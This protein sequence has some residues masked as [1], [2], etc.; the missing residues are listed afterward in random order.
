MTNGNAS[1]AVA[2][3]ASPAATGNAGRNAGRGLVW[4]AGAKLYFI[5]SGYAVQLLL[6]RLLGS[7]ETFGLFS[8][9]LSQV[10]ILN[11]VL[12]AATV[13]AVSRQ[14]SRD[15]PRAEQSL[16]Q[17]LWLQLLLGG[18]LASLLALGAPW[19][20]GTILLD[21][22][23]GVLLRIAAITVFCY[24][25]YAA[26]I[27]ALNGKQLFHVQAR[28][29]ATYTTSRMVGMLGAAALGFGVAGAVFGLASAALLVLIV[30]TFVVGVGSAGRAHDW[31]SWLSF[32]APLWLY[33]LCINLALQVDLS[34]LK[35]TV[36]ALALDA[37][38]NQ[39]A[40]ADA[41]SR[42]AGFYRAAQTFAFVPYQL[43]L[44][45]TFVV[46]PMV[47]QAQSAG[48]HESSRRYVQNALRFSLLVL[49][50]IAAPVSGAAGGVMRLAYPAA[51][52]S[53]SGALALL[54]PGMVCF[55]LFVIGATILSGSGRP[56]LSAV[57][58]I[59]TVAVVMLCNWLF[60]RSAGLGPQTLEAA[61]A[62]TALGMACALVAMAVAIY[63][64]FGTFIPWRSCAR[65]LLAAAAAW[66]IAHILPA[67]SALSSLCALAA[68]ALGFAVSVCLFGE[69]NADDVGRV[70]AL[71]HRRSRSTPQ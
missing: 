34:V 70:R 19:L 64:C 52:L 25:L 44:S 50:A 13:Q 61:A 15:L 68:G 71:L 1:E 6:P 10:S 35:G 11:N 48:D 23:L 24:A 7:P 56:Q 21:A 8:T 59:G 66:W 62:G 53:G 30:A 42:M 65:M 45:V 54:A 55:A 41:A 31:R 39:A 46:F 2:T 17:A 28:L 37:G 4:I 43:I 5:A 69:I 51:Y 49:L 38:M 57:I 40:A 9:A 27:G 32:M 58:A 29:D 18:A 26:L 67:H 12:I 22:K 3:P 20:A 16:R 47:S 60:V 63:S 36:A 14:V 33:Q